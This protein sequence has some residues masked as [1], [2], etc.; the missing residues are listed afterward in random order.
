MF[1]WYQMNPKVFLYNTAFLAQLP[2]LLASH[3]LIKY[4]CAG[5][6]LVPSLYHSLRV[7]LDY[8]RPKDKVLGAA[9]GSSWTLYGLFVLSN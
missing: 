8:S 1:H 9:F 3:S 7:S 2:C 6:S 5:G 4:K